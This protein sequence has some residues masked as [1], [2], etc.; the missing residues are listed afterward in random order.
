MKG[1]IIYTSFLFQAKPITFSI[2]IFVPPKQTS[3]CF[4]SETVLE[5]NSE[6]SAFTHGSFPI[7]RADRYP[8]RLP[9]QDDQIAISCDFNR[10]MVPNI[11]FFQWQTFTKFLCFW[12]REHQG[13]WCAFNISGLHKQWLSLEP[14]PLRKKRL[15]MWSK[16][17]QGVKC[18]GMLRSGKV[19][20]CREYMMKV[21]CIL[22]LSRILLFVLE[23]DSKQS[24]LSW[25]CGSIVKCSGLWLSSGPCC[26]LVVDTANLQTTGQESSTGRATSQQVRL[27][28]A[29]QDGSIASKVDELCKF[30]EICCFWSGGI[31][32]F[33][34][35]AC[36]FLRRFLYITCVISRTEQKRSRKIVPVSYRFCV[37]KNQSSESPP[38]KLQ[39][40]LFECWNVP[41]QA[42]QTRRQGAAHQPAILRSVAG[43][44]SL[45]SFFSDG[46][47]FL[48][49]KTNFPKV[50]Q[51]FTVVTGNHAYTG[52][53]LCKSR[54]HQQGEK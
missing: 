36:S 39:S 20:V 22:S 6:R 25:I 29:D 4:R 45:T 38:T 28:V 32:H 40:L 49:D 31:S 10:V 46:R 51:H 18:W 13:P 2:Y 37:E 41:L 30:V 42:E 53:P 52:F 35:F 54:S 17:R 1:R 33:S 43:T 5:P 48:D 26:E 27:W 47:S 8:P 7:S 16:K 9:L 21:K 24:I 19:N 44:Q 14:T 15:G 3:Q 34:E 11:P 12:K 50:K 23:K